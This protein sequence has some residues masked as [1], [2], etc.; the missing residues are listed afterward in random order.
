MNDDSPLLAL[1]D[2][3]FAARLDDLRRALEKASSADRAFVLL[4][5]Q[6]IARR[7]AG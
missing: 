2:P 7:L 6:S 5:L 1:K 4:Q 3:R